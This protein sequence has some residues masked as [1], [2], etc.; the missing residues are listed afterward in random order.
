MPFF[1]KLWCYFVSGI[2]RALPVKLILGGSDQIA[3]SGHEKTDLRQ[4]RRHSRRLAC[5]YRV[6]GEERS[7]FITNVSPCGFFV[8]S[9]QQHT[10]G[11]EI[12]VTIEH[13]PTPPIVVF[14]RVVRQREA[15]RSV[16]SI[17]QSGIG[18]QIHSASEDYYQLI[19]DLELKE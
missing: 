13:E 7:G 11:T 17:E 4:Y 14:G 9:R 18:V 5:L 16:S 8:Q 1:R 12:M 2:A 6:E 10:A 3:M 15:H 19:F